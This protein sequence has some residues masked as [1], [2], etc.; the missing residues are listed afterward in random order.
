[1]LLA[2]NIGNTNITFGGYARD[3]RLAFSS[4]LYS[5]SALSSDELCYKIINMLDLYGVSPLDI[6]AVILASVVP[7]LTAACVKRCRR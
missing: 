7:V 5:D 6:E 4:R 1:M 3:G 2:F